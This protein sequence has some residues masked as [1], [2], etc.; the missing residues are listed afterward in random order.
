MAD[1]VV[2]R[3]RQQAPPRRT[4]RAARA[5][6]R[7]SQPSSSTRAVYR[8][9]AAVGRGSGIGCQDGL[10][11]SPDECAER[12]TPPRYTADRMFPVSDVIPS[13]T[14]PFVTIGL[15]VVNALG[16]SLRAHAER[17]RPAAVRRELYGVVPADSAWPSIADE[18]VP[19]RRLAALPREHA[20]SLDLRRQRRGSAR[21]RPLPALLSRLRRRRG[22]RPG[23][24]PTRRRSCRWSARAARSPA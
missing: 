23:R 21:P 8:D 20:L 1:D 6:R 13:R 16:V 14:T 12:R 10:R 11:A 9:R 5:R 19:P 2:V 17:P 24:R 15:I 18:H 4:R 3:Q 7:R 22:A